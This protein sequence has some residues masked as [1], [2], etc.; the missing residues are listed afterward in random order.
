MAHRKRMR[1]SLSTGLQQ[2]TAGVDREARM[3]R[4]YSVATRG[5]AG[6]WGK[7]LDSEFL[8]QIVRAG[9]ANPIGMKSRFTHPGL[10]SD[11]LGKFLGRT[12]DLRRDGDHVLGDLHFAEVGSSSP[13]G[14]LAGYVMNLAEEDPDAFGA[15]IVFY[16]DMGEQDRF[17]AEH[18]DE[19]GH[20]ISPD[21]DNTHNL[22]HWRL[23]ELEAVD[24]VDSPAAN[25][26]MFSRLEQGAL[27]EQA[28]RWADWALA[29]SPEPPADVALGLGIE[30]ERAREWLQGYLS[31]R[32]LKVVKQ[33]GAAIGA[34]P[35]GSGPPRE[36]TVMP[37]ETKE[38]VELK[39]AAL[40]EEG[41]KA[42]RE[43]FARLQAK[44]GDRPDFVAAEFAGGHDVAE[45]DVAL[46][47][48]V[49]AEQAE[50]IKRL[51]AE[52]GQPRPA[53]QG[54]G[55]VGHSALAEGSQVD[56][57]QLVDQYEASHP[58]CSRG[59]AMIEMSKRHPQLAD[60]ACM[61]AGRAVRT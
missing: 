26:G 21:P 34:P 25:S 38:A 36:E 20:F 53:S 8:D 61:P 23:A 15:S 4:D 50:E 59:E 18:E 19:D 7:W 51:K 17:R 52:A 40:R 55:P 33:D 27:A 54:T 58:G 45:A 16:M 29:L 35:Q 28:D 48:V 56:F 12:H 60:A 31:R 3:I 14:D 2:G 22:P 24:V 49:I 39:A 41:Q 9:N 13:E 46:K 42:E 44:F 47:D 43:R 5:E 10:C 30:S 11:G 37:E 6:G 57:Y 1:T 32:G